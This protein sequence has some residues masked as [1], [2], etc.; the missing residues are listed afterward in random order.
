MNTDLF[1]ETLLVTRQGDRVYTTSRKV[2]E[3][4]GKRHDN[5]M[6][7]IRRVIVDSPQEE[8]L[9][10]FE[11][12]F[13]AYKVANGAVRKRPV[14]HL[15]H[16]GFLMIAMSFTGPRTI[17]WK[18]KFIAAF[19]EMERQLAAQKDREVAALDKIRPNLRVAANDCAQGLSRHVT[20]ETLGKSVGAVTYHR[21][22][23]RRFGLLPAR[24]QDVVGGVA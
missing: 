7:L 13:K 8:Q 19:R 24:Q 23:A 16:D 12:L 15:S 22:Q 18:W 17:E 1:P 2:A 11:E 9:L 3:H 14:F 20:A 4:F 5:V 10:N 6:A 21:G